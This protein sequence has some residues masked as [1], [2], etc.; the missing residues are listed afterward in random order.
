MLPHYDTE[1][2]YATEEEVG[3]E[4]WCDKLPSWRIEGVV[5]FENDLAFIEASLAG[6]P[7]L[8][9]YAK[10]PEQ[11]VCSPISLGLRIGKEANRMILLPAI[12]LTRQPC[13]SNSNILSCTC[14]IFYDILKT[15]VQGNILICKDELSDN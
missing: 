5:F 11:H 2:H 9:R 4:D 14:P 7:H 1:I 13:T 8:P 10:L 3:M 6:G 12:Q 15:V